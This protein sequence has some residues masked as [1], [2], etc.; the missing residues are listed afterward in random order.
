MRITLPI[1]LF[2]HKSVNESKVAQIPQK[3]A[4][5]LLAQTQKD[6]LVLIAGK[7]EV[8][9]KDDVMRFSPDMQRVVKKGIKRRGTTMVVHPP[10]VSIGTNL[11]ALISLILS[12]DRLFSLR[13]LMIHPYL[14]LHF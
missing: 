12:L 1:L 13:Q 14:I 9:W 10:L 7:R 11:D 8:P 6:T 5:T 3:S 2:P 4:P